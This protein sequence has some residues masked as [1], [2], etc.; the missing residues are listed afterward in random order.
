MTEKENEKIRA[1]V[2]KLP[3]CALDSR[4]QVRHPYRPYLYAW[5]VLKKTL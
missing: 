4:E 3:S 1:A 2:R 5:K